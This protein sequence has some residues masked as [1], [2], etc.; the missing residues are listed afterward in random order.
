MEGP[1]LS[2]GYEP[3]MMDRRF[4]VLSNATSDDE[5]DGQPRVGEQRGEPHCA[6]VLQHEDEDEDDEHSRAAVRRGGQLQRTH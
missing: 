6:P 5:D 3:N 4:Y 2:S 1:P